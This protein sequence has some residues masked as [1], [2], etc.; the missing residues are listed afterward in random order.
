MAQSTKKKT[1]KELN[2]DVINLAKEFK[3][4]KDIL[5]GITNLRTLKNL[6]T[7]I[8]A[9]E[10]NFETQKKIEEL[11]KAVNK[12]TLVLKQF[13][14]EKMTKTD[15]SLSHPYKVCNKTF[16]SRGNLKTHKKE[17]HQK[18]K[19]CKYCEE[20]FEQTYKLEKHLEGHKEK[21]F[22]CTTCGKRF[23]LEWRLK[24]HHAS[25][26]L[27]TLKKCHYFNNGKLC[28]FEEIGCMFLH[29]LSPKCIFNRMCKNKMCP[30]QHDNHDIIAN[31]IERNK[32]DNLD[33]CDTENVT[34]DRDGDGEAIEEEIN[35]D[36]DSKNEDLECDL[37]GKIFANEDARIK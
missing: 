36:S 2:V 23:Q 13:S 8:I 9:I 16:E 29:V 5:E 7:K 1:V 28:P 26:D 18:K 12:N 24:K 21:E 11:E 3:Q 34:H 14:E 37:C 22:E 19:I 25:H 31:E 4:F 15:E 27:K 20:T 32:S 30:Y 6:D 35:V 33:I 17:E 10:K